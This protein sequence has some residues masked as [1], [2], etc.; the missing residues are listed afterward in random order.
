MERI[1]KEIKGCIDHQYYF[2]ALVLAL[3]LPDVCV[4]FEKHQPNGVQTYSEWCD[5][6]MGKCVNIDGKI[7]YALRCAMVH[8]LDSNI[9]RQPI[10]NKYLKEKTESRQE[11]F[12]FYIPREEFEGE[13]TYIQENEKEI[14]HELCVSSLAYNIIGGYELFCEAY[15]G[16]RHDY[17]EN[18]I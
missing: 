1:I 2:A 16:F 17:G 3:T 7:I 18:W 4:S 8:F 12:R 5:K 10:Y 6:W 11:T 13:I 15:P 14:R 9:E